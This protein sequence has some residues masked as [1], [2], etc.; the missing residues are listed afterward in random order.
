MRWIN[1]TIIAGSI[2]AAIDP[3][4]VPP[5]ILGATAPDWLEWLISPVR[6]IKH[7]GVTHYLAVWLFALAF[8][9]LAW[10]FHRLGFA[11]AL[12][13]LFHLLTDA[14]TI[15]GIP[16][17]WWSDRRFHLFG[18]KLKTGQPG[19]YMVSAVVVLICAMLIWHRPDSGFMPYFY[20]WSGYYQQGL[21]DGKEW[22]DNRF[23]FL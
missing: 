12:G 9:W 13:G 4:L 8:F 15:C 3:V 23:R 19:E 17:G 21:I 16:V 14:M 22:K 7:R 1:H 6:K 10:D 5:A 20:D 18:G 2:S 11:F